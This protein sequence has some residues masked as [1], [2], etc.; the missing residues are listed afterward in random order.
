MT[1]VLGSKHLVVLA[2]SV[3]ERSVLTPLEAIEKEVE[4]LEHLHPMEVQWISDQR[5]VA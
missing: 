4:N 2:L 1:L 3:D 5:C